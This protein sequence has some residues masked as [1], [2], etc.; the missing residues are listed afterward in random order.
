M[1]DGDCRNGRRP[2]DAC[3]PWRPRRRGMV[4]FVVTIVVAMV[5]LSA[6]GLR[7]AKF[8]YIKIVEYIVS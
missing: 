1:N 5:T 7:E 8:P 6:Y 2:A 4:L 3:A